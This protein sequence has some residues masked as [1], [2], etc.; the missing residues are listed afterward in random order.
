MALWVTAFAAK[1]DYFNSVPRTHMVGG[2]ASS[3]LPCEPHALAR[4]QTV[5]A[6]LLGPQEMQEREPGLLEHGQLI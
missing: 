2:E 5:E 1:A 4:P 6:L 3:K